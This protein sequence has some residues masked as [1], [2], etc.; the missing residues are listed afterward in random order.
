MC[1][2]LRASSDSHFGWRRDASFLESLYRLKLFRAAV[3]RVNDL[4]DLITL[5][6][7]CLVVLT[8]FGVHL[9]SDAT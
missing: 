3:D 8:F 9:L 1:C 4:S 7:L 5:F 6:W 2:N